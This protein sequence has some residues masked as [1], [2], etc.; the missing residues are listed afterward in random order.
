MTREAP[1]SPLDIALDYLAGTHPVSSHAQ[2][3][4]GLGDSVAPGRRGA[5]RDRFSGVP[6]SAS[7]VMEWAW[8]RAVDSGR[9]SARSA[10]RYLVREFEPREFDETYSLLY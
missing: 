1:R 8:G 7:A 5:E 4:K 10:Q 9:R 6:C 3:A 2:R